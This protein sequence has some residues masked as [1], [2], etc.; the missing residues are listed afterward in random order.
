MRWGFRAGSDRAIMPGMADSPTD[1]PAKVLA[2]AEA[3]TQ[4]IVDR[5][6]AERLDQAERAAQDLVDR[7]ARGEPLPKVR[8]LTPGEARAIDGPPYDQP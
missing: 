2:D 1:V 4:V 7:V 8:R 5:L 3:K 6:R